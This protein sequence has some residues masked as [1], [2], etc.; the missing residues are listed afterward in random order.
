MGGLKPQTKIQMMDRE[1]KHDVS[2]IRERVSIAQEDSG[3]SKQRRSQDRYQTENYFSF[4]LNK[5]D[6]YQNHN[7]EVLQTKTR[8]EGYSSVDLPRPANEVHERKSRSYG[9]VSNQ[10]HRR[11]SS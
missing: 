8:D 2:K 9:P 7:V 4:V 1:F 5:H 6:N 10:H 3:F 11:M